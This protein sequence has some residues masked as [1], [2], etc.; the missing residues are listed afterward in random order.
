M[1]KLFT[2]LTSIIIIIFIITGCDDIHLENISANSITAPSSDVVK[3]DVVRVV[4]G[5]TIIIDLDGENTKVRLIGID[6]PESVHS[7]ESKNCEFGKTASDYT[8]GL[9][10]NK[11]ISLEYDKDKYDPYGRL[12]AYVYLDDN[13][14]NYDLVVNGYAVAKEYK[15]NT[16]YADVFTYAQIEAEK[17]K[18]GMWS[19]NITYLDCNLKRDYYINY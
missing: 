3:Y 8:K 5:D 15:P 16:K 10:S 13:M 11:K 4:D 14:V 7:D 17:A 19:E 1:K 9:L 6:T 18:S 12:L 2:L